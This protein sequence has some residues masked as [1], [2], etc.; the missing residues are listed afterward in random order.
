MSISPALAALLA[1]P[2]A[3]GPPGPGPGTPGEL[4]LLGSLVVADTD[5][6]GLDRTWD[7][8]LTVVTTGG[9]GQLE[10]P[11]AYCTRAGL[12]VAALRVALRD[13]DDPAGNVRRV[14]AAVD[15]ARASGALAEETAVQIAVAATEPSYSWLAVADEVAGAELHL[16]LPADALS[17]PVLAAWID[18][19]LDRE[20]PFACL[21]GTGR[22]LVSDG[23]PGFLGLLAGTLLAFDGAGRPDVAAALTAAD[24]ADLPDLDQLARARRWLT[25]VEAP[26]LVEALP[27]LRALGALP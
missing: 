7:T 20:T 13:L 25:A 1:V 19:A 5:L 17:A 15:A 26:G 12:P 4:A 10:G 18:A 11:A 6:P 8:P 24:L 21:R 14:I 23:V 2:V 22:A 27:D 9:A 16:A 3:S